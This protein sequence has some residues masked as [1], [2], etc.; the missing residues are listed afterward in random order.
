MNDMIFQ[1]LSGLDMDEYSENASMET[2]S[3]EQTNEIELQESNKT[4]YAIFQ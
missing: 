2:S 4:T 1:I 3:N